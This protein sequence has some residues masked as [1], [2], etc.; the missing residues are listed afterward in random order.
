M[1]TEPGNGDAD[2]AGTFRFATISGDVCQVCRSLLR[3]CLPQ[4][5]TFLP[6]SL[7]HLSAGK[8]MQGCNYSEL[9]TS[10]RWITNGIREFP[11]DARSYILCQ[12]IPGFIALP[13]HKVPSSG[14][15]GRAD[16]GRGDVTLRPGIVRR[17]PLCAP[18]RYLRQTRLENDVQ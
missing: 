13:S 17:R 4:D 1:L 10:L 12:L 11:C 6:A 16:S 9:L 7:S 8:L 14:L 18:L 15:P 2:I 3:C 5:G